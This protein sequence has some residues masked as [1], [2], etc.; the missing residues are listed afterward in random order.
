MG[1]V[2]RRFLWNGLW[3]R[4]FLLGSI[5]LAFGV[6]ASLAV[7]VPNLFRVLLLKEGLFEQLTHLFLILAAYFWFLLMFRRPKKHDAWALPVV[8]VLFFLEET[9]WIQI[10]FSYSTPGW[11]LSIPGQRT[12]EFNFHNNAYGQLLIQSF[13]CYFLVVSPFLH[14]WKRYRKE[15]TGHSPPVS[16]AVPFGFPV[17]F[18]T[19]CFCSNL[20]DQFLPALASF[21]TVGSMQELMD[22]MYAILL[23]Q[24]GRVALLDSAP[25][26]TSEIV[27][28]DVNEPSFPMVSLQERERP[29]P[30]GDDG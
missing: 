23:F 7:F 25:T 11:M 30:V 10:Y 5:P 18:L 14:E 24:A 20:F 27:P 13:F 19:V 12:N 1:E 16:H 6:M 21:D 2:I 3:D 22:F 28:M 4:R 15:K 29:H 17:L 8:A 26:E 9:N